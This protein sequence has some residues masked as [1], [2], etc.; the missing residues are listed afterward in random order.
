[1]KHHHKGTTERL[2][3]KAAMEKRMKDERKAPGILIFAG[4]TEGRRLAEYISVYNRKDGKCSKDQ[5]PKKNI[6]PAMCAR[7]QNMEKLFW[8]G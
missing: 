7:H 6:F 5:R 1:M 8:T 4:T 3:N 2:I